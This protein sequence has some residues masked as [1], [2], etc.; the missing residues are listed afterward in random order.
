MAICITVAMRKGGV[1]KT[2]TVANI[3]G[4]MALDKKRVL[5]VDADSQGNCTD[6]LTGFNVF[7][8]KYKDAGI[9]DMLRTRG[10]CNTKK[11]I[12]ETNVKRIDILPA[13]GM[14]TKAAQQIAILAESGELSKN[15]FLADSLSE[16]ADDYDYIIIDTAPGDD[17]LLHNALV[18]S[19]FVLVP[20]KLDDYWET[21]LNWTYSTCKIVANEEN[22]NID[23]LGVF[24]TIVEKVSQA[25]LIR[26]EIADS[27]F[28]KDVFKTEIRKN[29]AA[30]DMTSYKTPAVICAKGSNVA[31]DYEALY[32]EMKSKIKKYG[33]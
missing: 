24:F 23:I 3:A 18:A 11:F 32:K 33:R 6:L 29:Q 2:A 10:F 17:L 28:G 19:D 26:E 8:N 7:T 16:V 13:N 9:Y 27:Q 14:S 12:S 20:C 31:K 25:K 4:L 30:N 1:G 15:M 22:C 5:V 21:S